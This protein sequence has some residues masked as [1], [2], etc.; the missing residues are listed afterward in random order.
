MS[1]PSYIGAP[2]LPTSIGFE[3]PLDERD[4][5]TAEESMTACEE[6]SIVKGLA[7]VLCEAIAREC[8][9]NEEDDSTTFGHDVKGAKRHTEERG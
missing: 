4:D 3:A 8:E 5:A 7:A 9:G 6:L 2:P 1:V